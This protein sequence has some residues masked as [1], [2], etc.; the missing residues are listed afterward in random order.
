MKVSTRLTTT[1]VA[2]A[3]PGATV[4]DISDA[5]VAGLVLRVGANGSKL[6][7]FRFKLR[8]KSTR[9]IDTGTL[10]R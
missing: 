8:G 7:L 6:W 9:R 5:A 1:Q 10:F 2:A 3:R 4:R